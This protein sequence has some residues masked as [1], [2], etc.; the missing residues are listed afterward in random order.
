MH[1][2]ARVSVCGCVHVC[3]CS[4]ARGS[5]VLLLETFDLYSCFFY[6]D[7]G[8]QRDCIFVF[9]WPC[10]FSFRAWRPRHGPSGCVYKNVYKEAEW[11][12]FAAKWQDD[13]HVLTACRTLQLSLGS[14]GFVAQAPDLA[15][16]TC[17]RDCGARGSIP[18]LTSHCDG[19][20]H[21]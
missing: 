8:P 19:P 2:C 15:L 21:R 7:R 9:Y 12:G 13:V 5:L 18:V 1:V 4:A 17:V 11:A 10:D 16:R 6:E 14:A 3:P 20:S